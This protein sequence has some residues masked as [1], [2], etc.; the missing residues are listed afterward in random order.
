MAS[1]QYQVI[2]GV[3]YFMG[4]LLIAS[5]MLMSNSSHAVFLS[6]CFRIWYHSLFGT[7]MTYTDFVKP[8]C[9]YFSSFFSII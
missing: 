5:L 7:D 2:S 1:A 9:Q 4:K 3:D 8:Q 6:D